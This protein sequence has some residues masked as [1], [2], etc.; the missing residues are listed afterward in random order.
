MTETFKIDGLADLEKNLLALGADLGAKTLRNALR[1][2]AKPI[3][4][5][6]LSG[7]TD[8]GVTRVV[9]TKK[10]QRVTITS[11]FLRSRTKIRTSIN[12]RGAVS[13][14]FSK[15]D[16]AVVKV[17]VFRVGYVVP[18]EYGANGRAGT[19][20]IRRSLSETPAALNIFRQR[21]ADRIEKAARKRN[22]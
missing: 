13:K 4:S 9:T 10:G 22:R 20:F 12:R 5:K 1:D 21:L 19:K 18:V 14:R 11:G 7:I 16:V 15:G 8:S 3:H 17:G 6:M 2:A